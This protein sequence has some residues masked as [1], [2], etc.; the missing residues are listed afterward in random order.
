MLRS[1]AL[2]VGLGKMV[3]S[4]AGRQFWKNE[5]SREAPE[6]LTSI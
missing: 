6:N 3:N 5:A 4:W 2:L 1:V